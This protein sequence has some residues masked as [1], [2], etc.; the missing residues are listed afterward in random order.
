MADQTHHVH[1][2]F[3]NALE[4]GSDEDR[5][6]YLDEICRDTP[7]V[8]E[9]VEALLRAHFHPG[10][11]LGETITNDPLPS[12]AFGY[13]RVGTRIGH[14]QLVQS[15]GE[16]GMGIVFLAEQQ[17][18]VVRQVALK[19]IKPGMDTRRVIERFEA[20]KQALA[21]MDHP[22]VAKV[23]DAGSTPSGRPYFVMELVHGTA[24]TTYCDQ[25]ELSIRE[26]LE[27]FIPVCQAV[28]HAHQ[29]GI[30]HRDLKPSNI[31]VAEF[32]GRP[33][34]KVIDFG[35]AKAIE[36]GAL[37]K[38]TFTFDGQIVG[39][40]EY[41]SP[42]QA[43]SQGLVDTRT[44][45]YSLGVVLYELLTG[46]TPF[47]RRRLRSAAWDEMM[48][49]IGEEEPLTPS[50][51]LSSSDMLP[52]VAARRRVEPGRLGA[53]LRGELDWIVMKAIDKQ[54]ARRYESP[55]ALGRDI[56]NHLHDQ[57]VLASPPSATYRL[58]KFTRRNKR[59]L[60]TLGLLALSMITG[61]V[62]SVYQAVRATRAARGRDATGR[63][64][65][66]AGRLGTSEASLGYGD[67]VSGR[68]V[69]QSRPGAG[70]AEHHGRRGS[71]SHGR[72][73]ARPIQRPA[74][75]EGL[76][77]QRPGWFLLRTR[78]LPRS[79]SIASGSERN[80]AAPS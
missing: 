71:G 33:V 37:G 80:S 39:T 23:L 31:L 48:R 77:A 68:V 40:P 66:G 8:R 75:C 4:C 42:E 28:Q 12:A 22:H 46:C 3:N 36:H 10:N 41:M 56:E 62:A 30:I 49:V 26:R 78:P 67:G 35:V 1:T 19:V 38:T 70:R 76:S 43:R 17:E 55:A 32:D 16:G 72:T 27:L 7:D 20:E 51:K 65:A 44:D 14:Y 57:S 64:R 73:T 13:E 58:R 52:A 25:H 79:R 50:A 2:I 69:S 61:T 24:I 11:Q 63:G 15:L 5:S 59:I 60:A 47:D 53:L 34:P 6:R 9:R 21:V 74:V 29:K 18:P 45:V 54:C